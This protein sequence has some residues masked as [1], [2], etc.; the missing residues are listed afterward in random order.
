MVPCENDAFSNR[1]TSHRNI[2]PPVP[3]R[4]KTSSDR[5]SARL[6]ARLSASHSQRDPRAICRTS[7]ACASART[8]RSRPGKMPSRGRPRPDLA[9]FKGNTKPQSSASDRVELTPAFPVVQQLT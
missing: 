8:R 1:F 7:P 3:D 5:S 6:S 9:S 4:S 2:H